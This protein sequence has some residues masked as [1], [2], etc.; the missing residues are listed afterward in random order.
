[1]SDTAGK[2]AAYRKETAVCVDMA[3][4]I[5]EAELL[6]EIENAPEAAIAS[7]RRVLD[8]LRKHRSVVTP[9]A[10]EAA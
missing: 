6:A 3:Y 8:E 4:G 5:V 9:I 10:T 7:L 2:H 1:M